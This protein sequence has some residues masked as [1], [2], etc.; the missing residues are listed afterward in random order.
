MADKEELIKHENPL[1]KSL[2]YYGIE[3]CADNTQI[4]NDKKDIFT[5]DTEVP[6]NEVDAV[7]SSY[8][9]CAS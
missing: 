8:S 6:D 1:D 3:G 4:M 5:N 7:I 2:A 9:A